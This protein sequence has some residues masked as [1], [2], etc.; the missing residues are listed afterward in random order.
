MR[1]FMQPAGAIFIPGLVVASYS[2]NQPAALAASAVAAGAREVFERFVDLMYRRH[3]VR[4]AFESCVVREGFIDH[5]G[6]RSRAAA[7]TNLA[8]QLGP[9]G[10]QPQLLHTVFD[11]D[12]GMVHLSVPQAA[13]LPNAQPARTRVEIFRVAEGRIVE[14]WSVAS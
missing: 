3:Q 12:I 10:S 1:A 5:A 2:A 13:E 7:M 14:H 4:A 9:A 11:G 8:P 6:F